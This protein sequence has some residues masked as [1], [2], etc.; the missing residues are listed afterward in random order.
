MKTG[1]AIGAALAVVF[2]AQL[3]AGCSTRDMENAFYSGA[4]IAYDSLKSSNRPPRQ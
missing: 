3:A 1:G 2:M 4:K